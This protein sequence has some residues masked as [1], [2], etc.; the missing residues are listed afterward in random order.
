MNQ[1]GIELVDTGWVREILDSVD[2]MDTEG[3]VGYLADDAIFRFGSSPVVAGKEAIGE[4]VGSFFASIKGLKHEILET[5]RQGNAVI[6]QGQVIYTRK[7]GS[8]VTIPFV[9]IWRMRGELIGEYLIYLDIGPLWTPT[10]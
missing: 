7:D 9:D 1:K 8:D 3:F 4:A 10:T 2:A 5:W 6:C